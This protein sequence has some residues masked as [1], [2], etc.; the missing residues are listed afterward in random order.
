MRLFEFLYSLLCVQELLLRI[1]FPLDSLHHVCLLLFLKLRPHKPSSCWVNC[2][3][4]S[5]AVLSQ[6]FAVF[7]FTPQLCHEFFYRKLKCCN[8][9][10]R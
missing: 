10:I 2:R 5:R 6:P 3:M 1:T 4:T 8:G 7:Q 9:S